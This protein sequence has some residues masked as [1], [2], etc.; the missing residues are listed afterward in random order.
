MEPK[1]AGVHLEHRELEQKTRE[2]GGFTYTKAALL[3][4]TDGYIY[5]DHYPD[6]ILLLVE[7]QS[8]EGGESFVV[9]GEKVLKRLRGDPRT[10]QFLPML[11]EVDVDLTEREPKG[12]ANGL[13]SRGPIVRR[14]NGRLGW[15][16]QVTVAA[17]EACAKGQMEGDAL[18]EYHSLWEPLTEDP[19]A[20]D[21]LHALDK[22]VQEEAKAAPR[23]RVQRGEALIVDNFRMLHAREKY[24]GATERRLWRIWVWT[25]ESMGIPEGMAHVAST[26]DASKL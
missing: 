11:E 12:I 14:V 10:A 17:G 21:M 20:V 15:R 3:P 2:A 6:Y 7:A 25:Q 5:G 1:V 13:E 22:A 16:R 19:K 4:H 8:E 23:F 9:D 24:A 26:A 18:G